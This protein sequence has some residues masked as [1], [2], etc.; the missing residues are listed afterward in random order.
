VKTI[1]KLA[2]T[3]GRIGFSV[4]MLHVAERPVG[5]GQP[6]DDQV[7][8]DG[9]EDELDGSAREEVADGAADLAEDLVHAAWCVPPNPAGRSDRAVRHGHLRASGA[10]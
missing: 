6:Q 5:A 4:P 9:L 3:Y 1:T 10:V 7:D 8:R 2:A